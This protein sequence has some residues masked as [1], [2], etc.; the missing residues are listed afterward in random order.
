MLISKHKWNIHSVSV[1]VLDL[2]DIQLGK[3]TFQL[4]LFVYKYYVL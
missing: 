4:T 2:G 1:I 3:S